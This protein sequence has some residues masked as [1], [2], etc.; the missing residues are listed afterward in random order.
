[1][2]GFRRIAILAHRI[3]GLASGLIVVIVA[4]TGCIY[5]FQEE[6]QDLTQPYR[7]VAA[8]DSEF[9]PPSQIQAIADRALPDKLIHGVMYHGRDRAAKAI[10]WSLEHHYYYFVYVNQYTGEVLKVKDEF[11]DFFRIVLDGHFY[12]WLPPEIGQPLISTATLIFVIILI[13]GI[14]LWWPKKRSNVKQKFTI[15]ANT[16]WRRR[17][18]DL[19]SVIGI[20]ASLLGLV[21]ALTGLIWGFEW[22]RDGVY[23][24]ASGGDKFQEYEAPMSDTTA[25][26]DHAIPAVDR[27]WA[28]MVKEY[29]D[30][31]SIEVHP[32]EDAYTSIAANANFEEGTYWKID[33][34][35]FDQYTLKEL[36]VDHVWGRF[37]AATGADTFMRMNYDIHTGAIWGLPG[38]ILAFCVSL[39]IASLPITGTLMWYGRRVKTKRS[40]VVAR[41]DRKLVV[42]EAQVAWKHRS[43]APLVTRATLPHEEISHHGR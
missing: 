7:F 35:Y 15:K 43:I 33:Y 25:I 9:L 19:H 39:L 27:V 1:M 34:R 17:N 26:H 20:Y 10:Y 40:V 2:T 4:L 37:P 11:A 32:P 23:A 12:L 22:F 29:P 41:P 13:T 30:A 16:R 14:I 6:L 42:R 28:M 18:Y 24:I 36:P 31:A 21:L 38:K 3:L 5:A 8:Q